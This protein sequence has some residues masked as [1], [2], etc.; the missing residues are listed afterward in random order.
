[1]V[2]ITV[3]QLK[4]TLLTDRHFYVS[5]STDE[6]RVCDGR[7]PTISASPLCLLSYT[8]ITS[9]LQY[10]PNPLLIKRKDHTHGTGKNLRLQNI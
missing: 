9:G 3:L 8:P 6:D 4:E 7:Y 2:V 5:T 10:R 1:M